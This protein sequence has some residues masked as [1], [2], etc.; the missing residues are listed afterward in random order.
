M[1]SGATAAGPLN[2]RGSPATIAAAELLDLVH[3]Q[4]GSCAT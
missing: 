4:R 2:M 3:L 1:A